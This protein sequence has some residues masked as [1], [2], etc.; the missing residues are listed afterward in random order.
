MDLVV[1]SALL[2]EIAEVLVV[3]SIVRGLDEGRTLGEIAAFQP[4]WVFCLIGE[5]SL[6]LK[7]EA[8][9]GLIRGLST[10]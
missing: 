4:D 9:H 7:N 6:E 10:S 5:Y 3:D 2:Q 1:Q 8:A